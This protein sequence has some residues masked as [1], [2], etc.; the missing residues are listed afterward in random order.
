MTWHI[1]IS[2]NEICGNVLKPSME[3]EPPKNLTKL[4]DRILVNH[5]FFNHI[6]L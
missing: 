4:V 5:P 3:I 6:A 2:H 1:L